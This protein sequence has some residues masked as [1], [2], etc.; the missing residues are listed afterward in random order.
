MEFYCENCSSFFKAK[1]KN[2]SFT[3]EDNNVFLITN[4]PKCLNRIKEKKDPSS[5]AV[6]LIILKE[7]KRSV[8]GMVKQIHEI[9]IK[10]VELLNKLCELERQKAKLANV[11]NTICKSDMSYLWHEFHDVFKV[12]FFGEKLRHRRAD[13]YIKNG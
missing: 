8:Y 10:E 13:K 9:E 5:K 6:Q 4:C 2:I 1:D 3:K 7:K 12:G 11:V